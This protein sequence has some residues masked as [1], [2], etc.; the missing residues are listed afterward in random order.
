MDVQKGQR[1][2]MTLR[3]TRPGCIR[4]SLSLMRNDLPQPGRNT[5]LSGEVFPNH[6][7]RGPAALG[8]TWNAAQTPF[9]VEPF[10]RSPEAACAGPP[11]IDAHGALEGIL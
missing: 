9:D 1:H 8:S 6:C 7:L 2:A 10:T 4:Y 5:T 3:W 11:I